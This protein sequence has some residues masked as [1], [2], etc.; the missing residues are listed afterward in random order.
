MY[1]WYAMCHINSN[2]W[3]PQKLITIF[4]Y[5]LS[6]Y[7]YRVCGPCKNEQHAQK[8]AERLNSNN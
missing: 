5:P 4:G 8:E 1:K 3:F 6:S 2:E 7:F